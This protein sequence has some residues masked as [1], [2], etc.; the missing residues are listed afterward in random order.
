MSCDGIGTSH[1]VSTEQRRT[2]LHTGSGGVGAG[3]GAGVVLGVGAGV[4]RVGADVVVVVV[5]GAAVSPQ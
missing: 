3:V 2:S 1:T 4:A 5:V